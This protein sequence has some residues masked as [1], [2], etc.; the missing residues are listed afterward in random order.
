MFDRNRFV[1]DI[2]CSYETNIPLDVISSAGV[3]I[4]CECDEAKADRM[5]AHLPRS[6]NLIRRAITPGN[7]VYTIRSVT[8]R[9]D[10]TF[11]DLDIDGYDY[12]VLEA[13]LK[14][15]SPVMIMAEINEK[16]PPPIRFAVKYSD[17]YKW[18]ASHF[19]GMSLSKL[20]D[21]LDRF[22]YDLVDL[23]Y[24]NAFA[25]QRDMNPGLKAY[26]ADEAYGLFYRSRDWRK[27]FPW[28]IN[29]GQWLEMNPAAAI[30]AIDEHFSAHAGEYEIGL[31][32]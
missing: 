5:S 25:I 4:F 15:Y 21:L 13:I 12:F 16:I 32:P 11:L 8:D 23:T 19:F 29:V 7:V 24:N 17:D 2:G 26:S 30:V 20:T 31:T 10:P 6:A 18:D 28:N 1:I 14:S 9:T 22:G 27:W 3:A